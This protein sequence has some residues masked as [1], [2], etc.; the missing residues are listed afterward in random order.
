MIIIT[1]A[2]GKLGKLVVE[3]LLQRVPASEVAVSVRD[4]QK[5]VGLVERGVRVRQGDFEDEGSLRHAFEGA[6]RLLLISSNAAAYGGDTLLQHRNAIAAAKASGV[7]RVFYASQVAAAPDAHF[8]PGL[9]HFATEQMLQASGL[10]WTSLRH[11]FY[12]SSGLHLVKDGIDTGTLQAPEDGPVAWTTHED[13]A[14]ADAALLAG[15]E[16]IDGPVKLTA[17]EQYDFAELIGIAA[18]VTGRTLRRD[19]VSIEEFKKALAEKMSAL[20]VGFMASYYRAA[21]AG[22]FKAGDGTLSRL[23]GRPATSMR[24]VLET[25]LRSKSSS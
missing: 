22:E 5:A 2:S 3:K 23:L 16:I 21:K 4:P 18:G 20:Q 15:S 8:P 24:A 12:A 19:T 25:Q 7:K 10:E 11:G 9:S 14:E 13:L 6:Q 17:D 1:G